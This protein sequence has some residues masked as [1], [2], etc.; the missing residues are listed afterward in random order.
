MKNKTLYTLVSL[1]AG[2]TLI[3]LGILNR[4]EAIVQNPSLLAQTQPQRLMMNQQQVDQHFIQ[5]MIPH[6]QNKSNPRNS[7]DESL[8]QKMVRH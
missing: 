5:M 8:V 7:G 4:T 6:H 3:G 2:G 1:V